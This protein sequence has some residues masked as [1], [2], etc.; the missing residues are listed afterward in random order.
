MLFKDSVRTSNRRPHFIITKINWLTLFKF[1][2]LKPKRERERRKKTGWVVR[3][4]TFNTGGKKAKFAA[5]KVPRQCPL[6]LLVEVKACLN[7]I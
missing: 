4:T 5:M 2:P 3:D 6:V 1:N 7:V